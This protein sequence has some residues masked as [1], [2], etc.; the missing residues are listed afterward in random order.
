MVKLKRPLQKLKRP[1][2]QVVSSRFKSCTRSS[3]LEI[4]SAYFERGALHLAS[5]IG[6]KPIIGTCQLMV[7]TIRQEMNFSKL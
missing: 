4:N 2:L 3:V 6:N 5:L 1:L 7:D